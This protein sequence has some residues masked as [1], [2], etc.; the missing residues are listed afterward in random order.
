[1]RPLWFVVA[2]LPSQRAH[3]PETEAG[4]I[5]HLFLWSWRSD[6]RSRTPELFST[7]RPKRQNLANSDSSVYQTLWQQ[8]GP[9]RHS[10]ICLPP[11]TDIVTRGRQKNKTSRQQLRLRPYRLR[12]EGQR[13]ESGD[14]LCRELWRTD[15]GDWSH[16]DA[17]LIYLAR[18]S[19]FFFHLVF[20]VE[21]V[22]I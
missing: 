13:G 8:A 18:W 6:P 16:D 5:T 11:C 22:Y 7:E 9:G 17:C 4:A 1:M 3:V 10:I 14:D 19:L 15:T 21:V 2:F 12:G 20:V